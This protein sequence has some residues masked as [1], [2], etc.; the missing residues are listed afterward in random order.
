MTLIIDA[1]QFDG[2]IN[3]DPARRRSIAL[4]RD[5]KA[6][7]LAG[8]CYGCACAK[9]RQVKLIDGTRVRIGN[10]INGKAVTIGESIDMM[11]CECGVSRDAA[12][13]PPGVL[14]DN[15]EAKP[16][17]GLPAIVSDE[18]LAREY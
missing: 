7:E 15:M 11:K 14:L 10:A 16:S 18:G 3:Q 12:H 6:R 2:R 5:A 13:K 9:S 17:L 1:G 8:R 4:Q